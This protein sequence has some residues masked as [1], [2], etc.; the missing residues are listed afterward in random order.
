MG[1]PVV[2][3]KFNPN[4]QRRLW[5][6]TVWPG[7]IGLEQTD[8]PV[9][10]TEAFLQTW[11]EWSDHPNIKFMMGQIEVSDTGNLHIQCAVATSDSKRWGWMSKHLP[12]NWEPASDWNALLDYVK[13]ADT[14]IKT[15]VTY[16]TPPVIRTKSSQ[17]GGQKARAIQHLKAGKDP[18]WIALHDPEVYFTHHKAINELHKHVY[19]A[20]SGGVDEE[21]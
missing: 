18:K 1:S 13:K 3:M 19:M 9:R 12:A 20:W 17:S 5:C 11:E 8:D 16:G 4:L 15:L 6:G 14:R 2:G 21:E 7:H 10:L